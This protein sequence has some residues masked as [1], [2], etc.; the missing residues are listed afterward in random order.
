M[1]V[2]IPGSLVDEVKLNKSHVHALCWKLVL[3]GH[4]GG[5]QIQ[6][7]YYWT[8]WSSVLR[9]FD[10]I[11]YSPAFGAQST[12]KEEAGAVEP[13][14][15]DL[16]GFLTINTLG[17]SSDDIKRGALRGATLEEYLI[18]VRQ[19]WVAPIDSKRYHISAARFDGSV[20]HFTCEGL[21]Y[22]LAD[23][24]GEY[25]GPWCRADLFSSGR[26]QCNANILLFQGFT[27]VGTIIAQGYQF[28]IAVSGDFDED[29]YGKEGRI[30]FNA[31]TNAGGVYTIK[32][33]RVP[34]PT[35]G[36]GF[37]EITLQ[38]RTIRDFSVGDGIGVTP[39][40]DHGTEDC[41]I[42]FDNLVNYQAEPGI[43]GADAATRGRETPI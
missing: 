14:S 32:T 22:P 20:W 1:A 23:Q 3:D 41:D 26:G 2:E 37:A 35:S 7:T 24:I 18:D 33:Y 6:Q 31:G 17:L 12:A 10:G 27:T 11:D 28:D 38:S 13:G 43:P 19:P 4:S 29:D 15:K 34:A 21:A 5:G 39:G 42:K 9:L 40:C 25:W 30:T 8:E 16:E 36:A